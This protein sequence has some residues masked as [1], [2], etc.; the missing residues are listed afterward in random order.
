MN[1][2]SPL[3]GPQKPAGKLA[4]DSLSSDWDG[5]VR[6]GWS[7]LLGGMGV[8][9]AWAIFDPLDKGVPVMGTVIV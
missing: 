9:L 2:L 3:S 8:F 7:V 4:P 5:Y 6:F 1:S